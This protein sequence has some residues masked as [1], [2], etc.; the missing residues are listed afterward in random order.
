MHYL[1]FVIV[2]FIWGS[3]FILM[4]KA[5]FAFGPI[6]IGAL[7]TLGGGAVLWAAF[8]F[9]KNKWK[10]RKSDIPSIIAVSL[11][12]YVWPFALQPFLIERIGHGFIG[13]MVSFVPLL[14]IL[15]SIPILKTY[16][17][18]LQLGGVLAGILCIGLVMADGIDRNAPPVLLALAVTVPLFY[19]IANSIIRRNF[20]H[21]PVFQLVA[22]LMTVSGII[23]TPFSLAFET[24]TIGPDFVVAVIAMVILAIIGRGIATLMFYR[25]IKERGPLFAGLVTYVVPM[26][27]LMWS[28]LDHEQITL[29]QTLA[30]IGVLLIVVVVQRDIVKKIEHVTPKNTSE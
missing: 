8:R 29:K 23:L 5:G 12:G 17:S 25:L 3:S 10:I 30:L 28:W 9:H 27:A 16:P 26:G 13:M 22:V 4:K 21:I 7:G 11:F 18:R 20:Q 19:A 2:S 24:I 14:T 6:S 1:L 15:V